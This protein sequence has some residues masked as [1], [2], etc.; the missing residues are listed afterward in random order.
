MVMCGHTQI[1]NNHI[2]VVV[3]VVM[4][5]TMSAG[6]CNHDACSDLTDVCKDNDCN[7]YEN[8]KKVITAITVPVTSVTTV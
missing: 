6:D 4:V 8:I 5:I 3:I 1:G 7:V 2:S